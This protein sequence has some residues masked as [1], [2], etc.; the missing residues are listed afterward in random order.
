MWEATTGAIKQDLLQL[1]V[2]R[3]MLNRPL[4]GDKSGSENYASVYGIPLS[5]WG[6]LA[7]QIE[8][9]CPTSS[10]DRIQEAP[11]TWWIC[12]VTQRGG[13]QRD[14]IPHPACDLI[15]F[16]SP[17]R[18]LLAR[19]VGQSMLYACWTAVHHCCIGW[20]T[21]LAARQGVLVRNPKDT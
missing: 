5:N 2:M 8:T 10:N 1:V 9:C 11:P 12:P 18:L 7:T 20:K 19:S 16:G 21:A 4:R 3:L 14:S 15:S 13:Q 6:R 17:H